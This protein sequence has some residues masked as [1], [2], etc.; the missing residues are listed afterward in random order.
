MGRPAGVTIRS[1][2]PSD[3]VPL[4][5]LREALWPD[6]SAEEHAHDLGPILEGRAPGTLPL[7]VLVAETA[8]D[9]LVGFIET[10]LRSHAEGCDPARAVGYIEGWF[11]AAGHR[12]RG[13]GRTLVGA[14]EDWARGQGCI[15]MASDT[16]IDNGVSQRA[17]E[18]LGYTVA[19]RCV[20]YRKAL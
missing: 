10:G 5:R 7:V 13:I 14:A 19:D 15:E 11:V 8:E 1:A 3:C 20:H 9:G 17:H 2:R 4:A 12:R 18:T 6:A 16:W